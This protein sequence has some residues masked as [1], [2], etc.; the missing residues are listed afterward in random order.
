MHRYIVILFA[1]GTWHLAPGTWHLALGTWHL[2]L[3]TC[4]AQPTVDIWWNPSN[5][6][7]TV[8][9]FGVTLEGD[10]VTVY[11]SIVNRSSN[12][13]A[14][15]T[16]R[17]EA[18]PYYQIINTPDVPPGDPRKEEFIEA[19]ELPYFIS[20]GDTGRFGVT[21]RSIKGDLQFPPD[22]PTEALLQLRVVDS[23]NPLSA[24]R[25]KT[26]LLRALK[27]NEILASN[28]PY[29]RFDS[30]YVQPAPLP[31]EQRF[32][33][34][35][36]TMFTIRVDSQ[37]LEM[38]TSVV[39]K[40]EIEITTLPTGSQFGP[41]GQLTWPIR[42]VPRDMG[43][44]SG[45]F[46]VL[47]KPNP[48]LEPDTIFARISGLG[49]M[50]S[51]RVVRA[52]SNRGNVTVRGDTIDFGDVNADGTGGV[53]ARIE[54]RNEGNINAFVLS[55]AE[56]GTPRD[57]IAFEV[58][59]RLNDDAQQIETNEVDTLVVRF[60]PSDGGLHLMRYDIETN[61]RSRPIFGI[62][63]GAQ[64]KR[65]YFRAFAR[66][67]QMQIMP[68]S[69]SFGTVVYL[70]N[71]P[72]A[73]ERSIV[74]RNVGNIP[75]RI[76]SIVV[77][78]SSAPVFIQQQT[79]SPIDVAESDTIK[80]LYIPDAVSVLD[81]QLVFYTNA[82][83]V[84][85]AMSATGE[86]VPPDTITVSLP[87]DIRARPGNSITIAVT[88][89]SNRVGRTETAHL[90]IAFDPSLLRYRGAILSGTASEG[91]ALTDPENPPGLL[92]I[93]LDANGSF[94]QRSTLILL[95]FDTFLGDRAETELALS[96]L[97]TRFGNV[98]CESV[99]DVSTRNG[100]FLID[101]VCGLEYKTSTSLRSIT[102]IGI[103][104]NPVAAIAR[105]IIMS[106]D[107]SGAELS[108]TDAFGSVVVPQQTEI[109][110]AGF[111]VVSLS[112]AHVT[113]GLYFVEFISG[114]IRRVLPLMVQ[115]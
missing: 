63:D 26:F 72:S 70:E 39:G 97:T 47:Y 75:L 29:I 82:F 58:L 30:V 3:P 13:V 28:T 10:P 32:T 44:D 54:I 64:T 9:D 52:P 73:S 43:R 88:V 112:M 104:P 51:L 78:P 4:N 27:T 92:K 1:L 16:S 77:I 91:S 45:H 14:I 50:Q 33:V 55:E 105:I 53:V 42:Y 8:M 41:R 114:R 108:V 71:C 65:L 35:N 84:P 31:P 60:N 93:D 23:A 90:E 103:A 96:P 110:S 17:P 48:D 107:S 86:S 80:I 109:L 74:V 15:F 94:A 59:R 62:P 98:G 76:D 61:L 68:A 113:P 66:K 25:N 20:R 87:A 85:Y 2:A 115:R 46:N 56:T 6:A 12:T 5:K 11:F 24:S 49:V 37:Y 19:D 34:A 69:L 18:D 7:D 100:K 22:V 21:Y 83:G 102:S 36:V 111:N 67:P 95:Q 40:P 38:Q 99:L 79:F 101:S 57:T 89:D 81:A 106:P